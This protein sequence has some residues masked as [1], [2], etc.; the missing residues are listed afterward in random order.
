METKLSVTVKIFLLSIHP[1]KGGT[2]GSLGFTRDFALIAG[3]IYDMKEE[4]LIEVN[5]RFLRIVS[6]K[7]DNPLFKMLMVRFEKFRD[8]FKIDK[9]FNRLYFNFRL[10]RNEIKS[11]LARKRLIRLEDRKFLF[12]R[13]KKTFI[14]ERM[15]VREIVLE[16]EQSIFSRRLEVF[17]DPFITLLEPAGFLSRIFA[18]KG[19]RR[20]AKKILKENCTENEIIKAMKRAILSTRAAAAAAT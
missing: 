18:D 16:T 19:K 17:A 14:V 1:E 15:M 11:L 2:I 3:L 13:W 9:W 6:D 5:D 4:G 12:F 7:T 20:E 10:T 8:P